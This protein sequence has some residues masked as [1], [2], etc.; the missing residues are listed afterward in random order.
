[1]RY[2]CFTEEMIQKES[3]VMKMQKTIRG[4]EEQKRS[5]VMKI[6]K[7]SEVMK[8]EKPSEVIIIIYNDFLPP[9]RRGSLSSLITHTVIK[10]HPLAHILDTE[11]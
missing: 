10:I 2:G 4:Y 6:Q 5:E 9:P 1:M 8:I 3:G 11:P 7:R